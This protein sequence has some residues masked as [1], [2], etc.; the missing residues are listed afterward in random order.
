[1]SSSTKGYQKGNIKKKSLI[2]NM[3]I[4]KMKLFKDWTYS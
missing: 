2:M 4:I 3:T 1:M